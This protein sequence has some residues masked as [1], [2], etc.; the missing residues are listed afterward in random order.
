MNENMPDVESWK[1]LWMEKYVF[2]KKILDYWLKSIKLWKK[3]KCDNL[4]LAFEK[5]FS[6]IK[7]VNSH[8]LGFWWKQ[9]LAGSI[10]SIV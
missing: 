7:L 1:S 3:I 10:E 5:E 6:S 2:I 8:L 9:V 4:I